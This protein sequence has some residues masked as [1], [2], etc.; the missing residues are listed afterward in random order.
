MMILALPSSI[1]EEVVKC[2]LWQ[3]MLMENRYPARLLPFVSEVS[4]KSTG[5]VDSDVRSEGDAN[6]RRKVWN[7]E[8]VQSEVEAAARSVIAMEEKSTLDHESGFMD[9]GLHSLGAV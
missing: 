4:M 1:E 5:V 3:S 9:M 2:P 7:M 8:E 6:S